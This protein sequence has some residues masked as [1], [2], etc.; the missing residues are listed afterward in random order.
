MAEP[1]LER[2]KA[3]DHATWRRLLVEHTPML[4]GYA[5]RLLGGRDVAEEVV[6]SALVSVWEGRLGFEGRCSSK[7]W[8]VKAVHHRAI[9]EL[10]RRRRFVDTPSEE[11]EIERF[12]DRGRWRDPPEDWGLIMERR[13]DT[14]A[15]LP[16]VRAQMDRLPH[17]YREALLLVDVHGMSHEDASAALDLTPENLRTRLHRGRRTLR[18]AV[19]R[20]LKEA[21]HEH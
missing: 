14:R 3:G 15:L 21:T 2:L 5:T 20:S 8:L 18:Q 19:E 6:Q 11:P 17:E 9:D 1:D 7:S 13:M 12:D 16:I 10:R 4:L